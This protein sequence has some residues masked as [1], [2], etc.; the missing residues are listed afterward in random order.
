MKHIL[1]LDQAQYTVGPDLDP[2]SFKISAADD[3]IWWQV[4]HKHAT[5][6]S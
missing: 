4:V 3:L 6:L 2:N 1:D 5:I